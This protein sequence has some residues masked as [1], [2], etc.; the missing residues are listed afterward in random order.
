MTGTAGLADAAERSQVYREFASAFRYPENVC[1]DDGGSELRSQ[2]IAC[3]DQAVSKRA[4]ALHGSAYS[5]ADRSTVFEELVRFYSY[6]G[7]GRAEDADLPDHISVEL[8]FMHYL[9]YLE[10]QAGSRGEA[11]DDLRLAQRDFIERHL[12]R[13]VVAVSEGISDEGPFYK[14]VLAE[15]REFLGAEEKYFE[16]G[17]NTSRMM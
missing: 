12:K 8:E 9:T 3:F 5:D 7:L 13:L 15:L 16:V 14:D 6:F 4:R 11:I 1:A 10:H 2:Y 17:G